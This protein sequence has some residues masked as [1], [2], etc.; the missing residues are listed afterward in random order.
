MRT[1]SPLTS[2]STR[3]TRYSSVARNIEFRRATAVRRCAAAVAICALTF[4]AVGQQRSSDAVWTKINGN[5]STLR[6]FANTISASAPHTVLSLNSTNLR[7]ILQLAPQELSGGQLNEGSRLTLPTPAGKFLSFRIEKSP[8]SEGALGSPGMQSVTYKGIGIDDPTASARLEVAPDGFHAIVRSSGG[9]FYID[10]ES[11]K[12]KGTQSSPYLSYFSEQSRP[13]DQP[14]QPGGKKFNCVV[15]TQPALARNQMAKTSPGPSAVLRD[16]YF[17][18]YRVAIAADSAYVD[19]V[20]N[21]DGFGDKKDQ[22]L[23]AVQR[24][25]NRVDEI[26]EAELGIKLVLVKNEDQLIFTDRGSDSICVGKHRR[27]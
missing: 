20:F 4:P 19:A 6:N 9:T 25:I 1:K 23:I 14:I 17:R 5:E 15:S 22:A 18:A 7:A 3:A 21:K 13:R 16:K 27:N 24:T 26:Y 12:S 11:Q 8:I 2:I 10:P